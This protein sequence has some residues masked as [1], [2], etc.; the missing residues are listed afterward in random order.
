MALGLVERL[1]SAADELDKY[2]TIAVRGVLLQEVAVSS[3]LLLEARDGM[4]RVDRAHYNWFVR[5]L[6]E[7][8]LVVGG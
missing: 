4:V 6:H 1:H 7:R 2:D 3:Q 8:V 5:L